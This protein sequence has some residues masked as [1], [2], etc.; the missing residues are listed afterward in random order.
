MSEVAWVA[1]QS[2][3][4]QPRNF[5]CSRSTSCSRWSLLQECLPLTLLYAHMTEAAPASTALRK[6]GSSISWS[7]CSSTVASIVLRSCSWLL[8]AKC[9]TVAIRPWS[10]MPRTSPATMR[11]ESS[12][13]SLNVSK[14]R[15]A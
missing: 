9:L 1:S 12:G 2:D 4:T 6:A 10:W 3:I 7:V 15:P 14:F 8:A 13:S 11:E 5:H